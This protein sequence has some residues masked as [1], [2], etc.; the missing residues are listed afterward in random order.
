MRQKGE[1]APKLAKWL[2][3]QIVKSEE[4]STIVGD[5]EEFFGEL[6]EERGIFKAKLWFWSQILASLPEFIKNS[7]YW[8]GVMLKNII[9]ITF[10][11]ISKHKVYYF[12][13]V[14]GLSVGIVCFILIALFITDELSYD[15]YHAKADRIYKAGVRA[16]WA[17]NEFHGCVSPAPFSRALVAEFPEVEVSTRLR[18]SGFPVIRYRDKVFSEERWYWADDTHF[19]VFTVPFLQGDPKTALTKPNSVVITESMARKYFGAEDPLGKSLNANNRRDYLITGVI[20]DVPHNS[21]VHYDFLASYIT[22]EDGSDQNWISNNFPTYFVLKE[23][24]SHK[25]FETKLQL[26]VKKYVAPQLETVFGATLDEMEASGGS[27]RYFIT[28]LTDIHLHSHLRFEHEPNSDIAYVYIF[29]VVALAILLIACVNF[30]NLATARSAS[31]AKE[32]GVRKTVGSKRAQLIRQF[33][34]ET[35]VLGFLATLVALPLI[36]FMLPVFNNLTGKNL[37]VP[38]LENVYTIPLLIGIALFVGLLA[39]VYPAFFLASFDPVAVFKGESVNRG[40]RSWMRNILVVFQFSVSVVLIIG[41]LVVYKQLNYIQ[42]KN[43]G[44]N[45]DQVVIVK[46]ADDIGQKIR[47]FKQELL[48]HPGI[49]NASNS[50]NLIGDFFGDSLFRQI[51]QPKEQN[52]LIWRM[53]TDK[54]YSKTYELEFKGGRFFSE[55][56]QEGRREVVLNESGA[57]ILGYEEAVG[58]KIIDMGGRDFTIIG[59]VK[60]FHFEPLHKE[61]NPLIILPFSPKGNGRY[62]SVRV[63]AENIRETL[64]FMKKSWEKYALNQAFE[65][66]FFDDHFARLYRSEEKTGTIFFSFSLLAILIASLGLF[67]LTAFITQQKT[68]EIGIRKV[69]GASVVGILFL[70]TRQFTRWV[71]VANIIAWPLAYFAMH[72]WLENFAYR[73]NIGVGTFIVSGILALSIALFT[74]S[75]QSIRAAIANPVESL[76]Y[77]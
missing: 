20:E 74:V 12:I 26:I 23:G 70:Y 17:D 54:D 65:Y 38:Y 72:K 53:W 5:I 52:Q 7:I 55:E 16:L 1:R 50:S 40:K 49:V 14:A 42:N 44:F 69:L 31:R 59:V 37:S 19:D 4:K 30:V 36:H 24:V 3:D 58:E 67:G 9:K 73:T 33:L 35:V 11:N 60:D 22:I 39:G 18:R 41:T 68:K 34:T 25:D 32:V 46:K 13:N 66:E 45:R 2:F 6:K 57:R 77:E 76:R 61:L 28:P 15:R 8:R 27:I 56:P 62:L 43:L 63:R 64:A 48:R 75:F 47:A 10:R 51:D 21:H 29:T 71:L